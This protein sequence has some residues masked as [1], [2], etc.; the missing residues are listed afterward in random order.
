MFLTFTNALQAVYSGKQIPDTKL[1]Q[2]IRPGIAIRKICL[3]FGVEYQDEAGL[4]VHF[5]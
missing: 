2:I 4:K 5:E 1:R 3:L